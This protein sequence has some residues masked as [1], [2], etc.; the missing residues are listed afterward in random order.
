MKK[1]YWIAGAMICILPLVNQPGE[2]AEN[3]AFAK[4][5]AALLGD[6]MH[7]GER[8]GSTAWIKQGDSKAEEK[9]FELAAAAYTKALEIDK[10]DSDTYFKRGEMYL[11]LQQY[12]LAQAD[13]SEAINLKTGNLAAYFKRSV[14]WYY[15][16]DYQRSIDDTEVVIQLQAKHGG[17]YLIKAVCQQKLGKD[18]LA[19]ETYQ[20]MLKNVPASQ[21]EA[22]KVAKKM[23]QQLGAGANVK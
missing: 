15:L 21:K 8:V 17:A 12:D 5:K 11:A 2:A 10:S 7:M 3:Q 1:L 6:G 22:I 9:K 16:H 13:Y 20:A 18:D 14:A 19:I 4:E 23:L